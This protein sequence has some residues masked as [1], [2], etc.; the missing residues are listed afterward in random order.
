M[1]PSTQLDH[2]HS[3]TSVCQIL[4][5]DF[6]MRENQK[7]IHTTRKKDMIHAPRYSNHFEDGPFAVSHIMHKIK[8]TQPSFSFILF[9]F[10]SPKI[11]SKLDVR[12]DRVKERGIVKSV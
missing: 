8:P 1:Y 5:E 3:K 2:V 6:L 4:S 10:S 12:V 11:G 9:H 7:Y